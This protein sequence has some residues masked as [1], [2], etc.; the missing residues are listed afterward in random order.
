MC[1]GPA[2]PGLRLTLLDGYWHEVQWAV[3]VLQ[4]YPVTVLRLLHCLV[5][6]CTVIRAGSVVT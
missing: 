2:A 4:P 3:I 1:A 6:Q 5:R